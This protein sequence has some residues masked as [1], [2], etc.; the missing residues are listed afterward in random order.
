MRGSLNPIRRLIRG[1]ARRTK[2]EE[3]LADLEG[4]PDPARAWSLIKPPSGSPIPLPSASPQR[5]T[6]ARFWRKNGRANAFVQ[7]DVA[8]NWLS[9]DKTERSRGLHLKKILQL[10]TV[11]ESCCSAFTICK[12]YTA[13]H[14]PTGLLLTSRSSAK[15]KIQATGVY[16]PTT[17]HLQASKMTPPLSVIHQT[18]ECP[19]HHLNRWLG[20]NGYTKRWRGHGTDPINPTTLLT[21]QHHGALITYIDCGSVHKNT[22]S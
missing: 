1:Q 5:M 7:Q 20:I 10:L 19:I 21:N 13:I 18:P 3:F 16:T 8:V 6:S 11:A 17:W 4:N 2:W 14:W 9:F 15:G 22:N 12:F